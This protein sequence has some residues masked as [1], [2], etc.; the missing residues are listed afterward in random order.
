[1]NCNIKIWKRV[2][3]FS[4]L[5]F[6]SICTAQTFVRSSD[7]KTFSS[8]TVLKNNKNIIVDQSN[9]K[10][11]K[12]DESDRVLYNSKLLDF[13]ISSDTLFFFDK[14]KEI[15]EVE[16]V[17]KNNG[18]ELKNAL[19]NIFLN[20]HAAT[21]IRLNSKNKIFVKSILFFPKIIYNSK[22]LIQVR[23]LKNINGYPDLNSPILSFETDLSKVQDKKWEIPLPKIIKYPKEGFFVDLFFQIE[24]KEDVILKPNIILKPNKETPIY[25]YY[26]QTNEWKKMSFNGYSVKLKTVR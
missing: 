4:F 25:F 14:I 19:L 20:Q 12:F 7:E 10:T 18:G 5:F 1:M 26:P 21:Y 23:I 3:L 8:V 15:E 2:L 9:F 11:F 24:N 17:K 16:I 6:L 22:G 13:S